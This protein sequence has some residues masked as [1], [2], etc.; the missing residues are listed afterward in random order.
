[1]PPLGSLAALTLTLLFNGTLY[2]G[3]PSKPVPVPG[4]Y[5]I[6][7]PITGGVVRGP[8]INAT[9]QCGFAHPPVYDNGTLQVPMIDVYGVSEDGYPFYIHETGIGSNPA[10]AT[11]IVSSFVLRMGFRGCTD[12]KAGDQYRWREV[13]PVER[14]VYS[15][16]CEC[17]SE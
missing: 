1:M 11:R 6:N 15:R 10:Q 16:E 8:T 2:L 13:P 7:E 4:G 12:A 9:I 3:K 17:E 14:G 5:L